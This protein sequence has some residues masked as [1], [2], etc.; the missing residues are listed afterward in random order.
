MEA[1]I[2]L[3]FQ[4]GK[5]NSYQECSLKHP[6]L[7][8]LSLSLTFFSGT[9]IR[10]NRKKIHLCS[11]G[12]DFKYH[13]VRC[14]VV[15]HPLLSEGL[16]VRDLQLFNKAFLSKWLWRFMNEKGNLW[17]KVVNIKYGNDRFG[18]FPSTPNGSYG[19]SLCGYFQRLGEI[20]STILLRGR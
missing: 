7:L 11:F 19:Y 10:S 20:L 14:N 2:V 9:Q 17:R 3:S 5:I 12:S 13:F 6:I 1:Y 18:W 8:P 15:N 4:R 16:G